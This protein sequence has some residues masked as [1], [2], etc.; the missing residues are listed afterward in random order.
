MSQL[1]ANISANAMIGVVIAI[2]IEVTETEIETTV[3]AAVEVGGTE[4]TVTRTEAVER[5]VVVLDGTVRNEGEIE[6][7]TTGFVQPNAVRLQS[8]NDTQV[9][10]IVERMCCNLNFLWIKSLFNCARN[11][12]PIS[13]LLNGRSVIG[14]C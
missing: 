10:V 7:E 4:T 13:F 5:V 9:R 8:M 2:E 14:N 3:V 12:G 1:Q 11:L 6:I